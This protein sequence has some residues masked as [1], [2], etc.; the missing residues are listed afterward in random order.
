MKKAIF[1]AGCFWGVQ[2]LFDSLDGVIKTTVGYTGGYKENPTYE[3]VCTS[4][5]GHAEAIE[6]VY[7]PKK[8]SYEQLVK[9]FFDI[10][11]FT[12][13]GGQGP[14]LGFQYRSE[15]FYF[16]ENQRSIAEEIKRQLE[17]KGLDIVTKITKVDKFWPAEDYHQKYYIRKG[18][19]PYCHYRRNVMDLEGLNFKISSDLRG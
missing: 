10:H 19:K 4:R 16:D 18:E 5:T 17:E 14:D 11:D 8:I 6:I 2:Y 12:Q 15:V 3:E 13:I 7:D 1:A 9:F